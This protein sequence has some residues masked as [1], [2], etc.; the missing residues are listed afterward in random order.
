M[1]KRKEKKKPVLEFQY[2]KSEV[3]KSKYYIKVNYYWHTY[4]FKNGNNSFYI[5]SVGICMPF[6]SRKAHHTLKRELE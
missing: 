4:Q 6:T 5:M 3:E 1:K 2:Q